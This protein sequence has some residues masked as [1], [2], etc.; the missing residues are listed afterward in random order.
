MVVMNAVIKMSLPVVLVAPNS[1]KLEGKYGQKEESEQLQSTSAGHFVA[2]A[3]ETSPQAIKPVGGVGGV[4][5][6]FGNGRHSKE[7]SHTH[8]QYKHFFEVE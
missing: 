2:N 3:G 5:K 4:N 6:R 8:S 7:E 1:E